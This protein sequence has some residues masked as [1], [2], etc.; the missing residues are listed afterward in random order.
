MWR[1]RPTLLP[2][3]T[4]F[5]LLALQ[6]RPIP[7]TGCEPATL[8]VPFRGLKPRSWPQQWSTKQTMM[9]SQTGR[10]WCTAAGKTYLVVDLYLASKWLHS[11]LLGEVDKA[12]IHGATPL[13]SVPHVQDCCIRRKFNHVS[14]ISQL[15]KSSLEDFGFSNPTWFPPSPQKS[16][17]DSISHLETGMNGSHL[18]TTEY[19]WLSES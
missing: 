9:T 5:A 3:T 13:P 4:D 8:A 2:S 19:V 11:H 16:V 1:R 18:R 7:A 14:P 6:P 17:T 15:I 10:K 12:S